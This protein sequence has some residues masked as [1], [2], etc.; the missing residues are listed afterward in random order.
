M[1]AGISLMIVGS[2]VLSAQ[3]SNC[4]PGA[5]TVIDCPERFMPSGQPPSAAGKLRVE[6]LIAEALVRQGDLDAAR[7]TLENAHKTLMNLRETRTVRWLPQSGEEAATEDRD[8]AVKDHAQKQKALYDA[9]NSAIKA[10]YDEYHLRP[11]T[12][13]FAD[14][15]NLPDRHRNIRPW[16]PRFSELEIELSPGKWGPRTA[17]QIDRQSKRASAVTGMKMGSYEAVTRANG[18]ISI[19]RNAFEPMNGVNSADRLAAL[20]YHETSHWIERVRKGGAGPS[21]Y[22]KYRDEHLAYSREVPYAR[23]L[24]LPV[25]GLTNIASRYQ[26]QAELVRGRDWQ[27][28]MAWHGPNSNDPW[29]DPTPGLAHALSAIEG[30]PGDPESYKVE[31]ERV[32]ELEV[33]SRNEPRAYD[34]VPSGMTAH[35]PAPRIEAIQPEPSIRAMTPDLTRLLR[36]DFETM[37]AIVAE[38]CQYPGGL[39][40]ANVRRFGDAWKDWQSI[41]RS[42]PSLRELS[43]YEGLA[44]CHHTLMTALLTR[45]PSGVVGNPVDRDWIVQT[46]HYALQPAPVFVARPKPKDGSEISGEGVARDQARQA[47]DGRIWKKKP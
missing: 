9:Y 36:A 7:T 21:P 30:D 24:G 38:A 20:I 19:F 29:L 13:S 1:I 14:D 3:T 41:I 5:R 15:S 42:Q 44:G 23:S 11:P 10:A 35:Q 37:R 46:A 25:A 4:P 8:R 40:E 26:R 18:D 43:I 28:T 6:T 45:S 34:P 27:W 12:E 31:A 2:A 32:F 47:N 22:D 33:Q 39:T 16:N 17:E